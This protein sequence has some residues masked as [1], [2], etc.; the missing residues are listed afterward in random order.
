MQQKINFA[1]ISITFESSIL[2]SRPV[3]ESTVET[4]DTQTSS[5]QSGQTVA[6]GT[7][8]VQQLKE[9]LFAMINK[10]TDP[11]DVPQLKLTLTRVFVDSLQPE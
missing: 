8:Q 9:A 7:N 1:P 5:T 6:T 3:N 4:S 11:R 2:K 10:V